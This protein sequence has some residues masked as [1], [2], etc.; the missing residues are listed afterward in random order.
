MTLKVVIGKG[1]LFFITNIQ[2]SGVAFSQNIFN[3]ESAGPFFE[4][5]F[6]TFGSHFEYQDGI[7]RCMS[8]KEEMQIHGKFTFWAQITKNKPKI[9]ILSEKSKFPQRCGY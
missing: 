2:P 8:F 5:H 1:L 6:G 4:I 7:D 9:V 3:S